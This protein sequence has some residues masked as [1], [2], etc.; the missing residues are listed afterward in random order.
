MEIGQMKWERS[1]SGR[2]TEREKKSAAA[3]AKTASNVGRQ[4]AFTFDR[5]LVV[6]PSIYYAINDHALLKSC[7][8]F[9][10]R[11]VYLCS[12]SFFYGKIITDF[13]RQQ[14]CLFSFLSFR[15]IIVFSPPVSWKPFFFL[16]LSYIF[17]RLESK[18][19]QNHI[20]GL[21]MWQKV[22]NE[23]N[24][25]L[26]FSTEVLDFSLSLSRSFFFVRSQIC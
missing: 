21:Q 11:P 12:K 9:S 4:N 6:R 25:N 20:F 10:F 19:L 7:R 14:F 15:F 22:L 26:S 17:I 23:I 1:E 3:S 8:Y 24:N 13:A 18:T 16:S 2:E 5:R